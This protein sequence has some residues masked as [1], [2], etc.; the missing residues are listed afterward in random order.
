MIK[1]CEIC[2]KEFDAQGKDKACS[3]E[4]RKVLKAKW[5]RD[6]R[7]KKNAYNKEWMRKYRAGEKAKVVNEFDGL[8]YAE[9]QRQ[10]TLEL[11]GRVQI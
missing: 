3:L 4:C 8:D 1:R 2:G 6:Y 7:T 5:H 9:R 11:V 10:R